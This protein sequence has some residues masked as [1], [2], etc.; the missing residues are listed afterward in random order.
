MEFGLSLDGVWESVR[1]HGLCDR[2]HT[3]AMVGIDA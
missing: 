2:E 3:V 1:L